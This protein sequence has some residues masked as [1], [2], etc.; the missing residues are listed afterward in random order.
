M[1][2]GTGSCV[3]IILRQSHRGTMHKH[4][5][6]TQFQ[7]TPHTCMTPLQFCQVNT[8]GV[9][10]SALHDCAWPHVNTRECSFMHTPERYR[11]AS[12][13]APAAAPAAGPARRGSTCCRS[14]SPRPVTGDD[15]RGDGGGGGRLC[16]CWRRRQRVNRRTAPADRLRASRRVAVCCKTKEESANRVARR[17]GV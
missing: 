13:S 3:R 6:Q 12:V 4:T 8:T 14:H 7:P 17:Q 11:P 2:C 5:A 9:L 16:W 10:A 1:G 15:D